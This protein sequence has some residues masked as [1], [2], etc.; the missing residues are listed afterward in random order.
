MLLFRRGPGTCISAPPRIFTA[1][2][3]TR[4]RGHPRRK[5]QTHASICKSTLTSS[6]AVLE[7]GHREG[8][9]D[10]LRRLRLD[11]HNLAEDLTLARLRGRLLAGFDHAH[12]RQCDLAGL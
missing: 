1:Q 3:S 11:H 4:I 9:H 6:D 8:L 5:P 10:R 7:G 12:T 2:L